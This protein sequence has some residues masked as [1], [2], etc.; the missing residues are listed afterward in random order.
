MITFEFL[1]HLYIKLAGQHL[2]Q[3]FEN[4]QSKLRSC[5]LSSP[6]EHHYL[7]L[8][9]F[10]QKTPYIPY[11][12]LQIVYAYLRPYLYL[13]Y[14]NLLLGA[15]FLLIWYLYLPKSSSLQTGGFASGDTSTRSSSFWS[16]SSKASLTETIPAWLPS[17]SI[18][19][20]S[21]ALICSFTLMC[22]L[23]LSPPFLFVKHNALCVLNYIHYI[24]N[25]CFPNSVFIISI[26]SSIVNG[27]MFSPLRFLTVSLFSADSLSPIITK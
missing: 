12:Q 4:H 17:A 2:G 11:F 20:T 9:P 27:P 16:A 22:L 24:F 8:M 14:V 23:I 18:S 3:P 13:F 1:L 6:E 5:H 10:I 21:L 15:C 25:A 19:L 7:S 26:S